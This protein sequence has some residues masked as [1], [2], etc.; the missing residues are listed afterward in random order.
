MYDICIITMDTNIYVDQSL[1][2]ETSVIYGV[3]FSIEHDVLM[4]EFSVSISEDSAS[5]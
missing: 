2:M 4:M 5:S 3:I 1:H